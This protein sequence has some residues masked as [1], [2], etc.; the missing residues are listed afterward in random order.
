MVARFALSERARFMS[1]VG[2]RVE[3]LAHVSVSCVDDETLGTRA[4]SRLPRGDYGSSPPGRP[5]QEGGTYARC[6]SA[7][8]P[9]PGTGDSAGGP[10]R[11]Y[12]RR[13]ANGRQ[14]SPPD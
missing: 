12:C 7:T 3:I 14:P 13:S 9:G 8:H 1:T 10:S 5:P 11:L 4:T 6:E 2:V